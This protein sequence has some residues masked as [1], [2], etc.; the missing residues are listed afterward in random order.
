MSNSLFRQFAIAT[1][2]LGLMGIA[3]YGRVIDNG[4][5]LDAVYTVQ[6]NPRVRA[7]T[8]LIE[9]FS[10]PY[11]DAEAFPGR[12]LYRPLSALS[13]Q[14]TRRL[15]DEPVALDHAINLGLHVLCGSA[16]VVFLL[17]MGAHFGVA[18]TL[19]TLFLLHPVQS[20]VVASLVER[21]GLLAT[22]FALLALNLSLARGC[23]TPG[24]WIGLFGLFSLSLFAK[25]STVGLLVILPACWAARELWSGAGRGDVTRRALGLAGCLGLAVVGN[26]ALRH[27]VLGDLMVSEV[28]R[29]DDGASGFFELRWRALAFASLYGEKLVWPHPLLPDYLTGVVAGSGFGLHLRALLSAFLLLASVAW[30]A[31]TW[32]RGRPLTR[33]HL[34]IL[35]FWVAIAPVSNLVVQIGTPFGERLF[36]FPLIFL[37][38]AAVDLP[39]WRSLRAA[40]LGQVPRGWPIWVVVGVMFGGLGALRIPEWKDNRSLF[41]AAVRDCPGNYYAQM[42]YGQILLAG[43]HPVER[44]G[45]RKAFLA[46][47]RATPGAAPPLA[48]LGNM[49]LAQGDLLTARS[50]FEDS[51]ARADDD[52]REIAALNLSRV[53]RA[54]DNFQ[55]LESLLV[56]LASEHPEWILLQRELWEYW[57]SRDRTREA[58]V[59]LERTVRWAPRDRTVW[60]QI[61][62]AHL[63]L[64]Q[65]EQAAERLATAPP[66][67]LDDSLARHLKREG[68]GPS[69]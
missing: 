57:L 31:F 25:E 47:A 22:L 52:E 62:R 43:G 54:L 66:G 29:L 19:A 36:Y 67:T 35:L 44:E 1:F 12:G 69:R 14:S 48:F 61:I 38:L 51:F 27:A 21:S 46:A 13:F 50:L 17:Q 58:L 45:A 39:V 3:A 24:S 7:D 55:A 32:S 37:L 8:G 9:I 41:Q 59:V 33:V 4:Y 56:P 34:G 64:G 18:L 60:R 68:L 42:T 53:Y 5:A 49:A 40:G 10:S 28:A 2:V 6:E 20:E 26:L 65:R 15:W 16:L 63:R 30:P 23:S 11:W